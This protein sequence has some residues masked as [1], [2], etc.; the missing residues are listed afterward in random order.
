MPGA[1]PPL[2]RFPEDLAFSGLAAMLLG[3]SSRQIT[4][5]CRRRLIILTLCGNARVAPCCPSSGNDL[6]DRALQDRDDLVRLFLCG[7]ERRS[8]TDPICTGPGEQPAAPR[9]VVDRLPDWLG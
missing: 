9:R 6:R 1:C 8:H 7:A 3:T 5:D 4:G 2:G